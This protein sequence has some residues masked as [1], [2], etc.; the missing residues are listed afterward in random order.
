MMS[1]FSAAEIEYL[2][3]QRLAR[4]ATAGHD[5]QPHV[6]PVAFRYNPETD[7][8]DVGGH[9]FGQRKKYR[10]VQRNPRVA[11]VI[12]DLASVDPWRPRMIEVRGE[13]E[14]LPTGGE[15]VGRGFDPPMF[16]IQ[17]KRIISIGIEGEGAFG[18]NARSVH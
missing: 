7:T 10:D 6:V 11:I 8:I 14:V 15:S 12:D 13:A 1:V 5:G 4:I 2:R 3:S 9:G 18:L 17:P 16:R